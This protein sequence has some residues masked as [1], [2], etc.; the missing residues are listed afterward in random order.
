MPIAKKN[1][2]VTVSPCTSHIIQRMEHGAFFPK[3]IEL[4]SSH[5]GS[6]QVLYNCFHSFWYLKLNYG[7]NGIEL[8]TNF[9]P[10]V[11]KWTPLRKTFVKCFSSGTFRKQRDKFWDFL[12]NTDSMCYL[13]VNILCSMEQF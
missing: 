13:Y 7:S 12:M 2:S 9:H 8:F 4:S 1:D 10:A 11:K 5:N 3:P 6:K